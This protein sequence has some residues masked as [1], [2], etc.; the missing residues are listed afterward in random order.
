MRILFEAV[1]TSSPY[2]YTLEKA[3]KQIKGNVGNS[4]V[5]N[6]QNEQQDILS[7]LMPEGMDSNALIQIEQLSPC[8]QSFCKS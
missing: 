7:W 5:N 3:S 8:F 4:T 6:Q 2:K 1:H